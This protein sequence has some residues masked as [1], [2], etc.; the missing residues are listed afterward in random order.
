MGG[1]Q[2]S[3]LGEAKTRLFGTMGSDKENLGRWTW[4]RL[5]GRHNFFTRIIS[6]YKPCKNTSD[7]GSSYQQQPSYFRGIG[8][9]RCPLK[10]FDLDLQGQLQEWLEE[11][12]Q[13]IL[14]VDLNEDVRTGP[15]AKML[16]ELGLTDVLI[17][18]HRPD[19]P[20]ETNYRNNN[21]VPIDAIF[22][23]PGIEPSAG[24]YMPY[25]ELMDS[26]HRALWIDVPF[27]SI[28]GHNFPH[29]S[30]RDPSAVNPRDPESVKQYT[31]W[32]KKGFA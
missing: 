32:V 19:V 4:A 17:Q 27:T 29:K 30:K 28:L 23:T 20:P 11:G 12:D 25:K 13:I 21:G 14:G 3:S 24:G 18:M 7:L 8:E 6:A 5:Q 1:G 31:E 2:A 16:R 9:F 26:D 15:T 10:M 22:T